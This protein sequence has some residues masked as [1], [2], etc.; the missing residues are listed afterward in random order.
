MA[1]QNDINFEI[2]HT[3]NIFA[4]ILLKENKD[5]SSFFKAVQFANLRL[6]D[7]DRL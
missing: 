7:L 4:S 5:V 3:K 1:P 6:R 2:Y